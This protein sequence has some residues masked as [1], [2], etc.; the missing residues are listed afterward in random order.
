[1]NK[2]QG[3]L[4]GF[5]EDTIPK[6]VGAFLVDRRIR[7]ISATS[8]RFYNQ[9]LE[10]FSEWW[11]QQGSGCQKNLHCDSVGKFGQFFSAP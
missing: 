6:W 11:N 1:M 5:D 3:I 2:L 7:N 10:P 8:N 4:T 9:K